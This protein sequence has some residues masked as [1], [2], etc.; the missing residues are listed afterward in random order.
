M[1]YIEKIK[2]INDLKRYFED[3]FEEKL[4]LIKVPCPLFVNTSSGLQDNLNG[5]E[6]A[7]SFIHD[8]ETFEIVHS[9]A[10]WKREALG[11]YNFNL[12]E[13]LYTDMKAIRSGEKVDNL[14]SFYVEQW[15]W[16][17]VIDKSD[18]NREY[19]IKTVK[20]IY[21]VIKNT[22]NYM[23]EKYEVLNLELP[24]DIFIISSNELE[25]LY[26]D[27]NPKEREEAIT[28][29]YKAV[30]ISNIGDKL[31][32][33]LVHDLRSPDYDDWSLNGDILI[34]SDI[35]NCAVEVSSM[36]IRV[37]KDSLI[38]QLQKSNTMDR[39]NLPYHQK[40]IN[41]SLPFTI[42]GG[43]G[44]SRILLLILNQKHIALVEASSWNQD[45]YNEFKNENI[46]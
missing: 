10:K 46:L 7:V 19:L 44:L 17:K 29:K 24:E 3:S 13:G 18:R 12:Y 39:V 30:F 26:P 31:D 43:I 27:I 41:D 6:K 33:G 2:M 32:S 42:G 36:G 4:N 38:S 28:K 16:E 40:I 37:D 9:L 25:K 22:N 21:E 45:L 5:V 1:E 20:E 14:H 23:K 11:K 35:L 34:Y 8:N 15:D